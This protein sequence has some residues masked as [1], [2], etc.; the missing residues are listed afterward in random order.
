[1][2][3]L[4]FAPMLVAAGAEAPASR[5]A[6]S[7]QNGDGTVTITG[8]L[9]QWHKIT[10]QLAGPFAREQDNAPNPFTDLRFD[11]TL[12][13]ESGAP[14]YVVPGYFAAD[15]NAANTSATAGHIW[16][17]HLTP[18]KPGRWTYRVSFTRG[19]HVAMNGG[20]EP[21]APFDGEEGEFVVATSDKVGRDFRGKGRLEYVGGRYLRFAGSG[22]LF[23]KAGADAPETLLAYVDFDGTLAGKK[24]VPLKT[25][26]PH[27]RDW[28]PGDPAWRGGRGKGLIGALN[29]LAAQGANA[30]S[31]LTYNAG[32]DGDNVWPFVSR[33]DK[34][35]YDCSKLD[36]WGI[37]FDHA[38]R[39][40]L[41]LH[42]KLQETENDDGRIGPERTARATPEALD[43]GATGPERRLYLRELIARFGHALALN[44][45]L[46]EENTQTPDEQRAMMQ[47]ITETD[48]YHH[49]IVLHSYPQEQDA[50]Y[51]P[52]L[53]D[54][55]QLTGVSLQ[56]RWDEAHQRTFHWVQAAEAA[57]RAWVVCNDEQN[58]PETG[59]PPDFGYKGYAGKK[60]DGTRVGYNLDD[61]RRR[62]LWG[63]LLAGGA[64][65]EYYF[66]YA[67]S[68]NDLL[69]EDFRSREH[70]WRYARAAL[71]FFARNRIPLASMRN[72][73]ELVG[74]PQHDNSAYCFAEPDQI[75]LVYLPHGGVADLDLT[76]AEHTFSITWFNPRDEILRSGG[77]VH[78]GEHVT[79][80]A[81]S[82][83]EDW[84]GI[85]RQR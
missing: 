33:H 82:G 68:Q 36:Q 21:L 8:Q 28:R 81:P 32:G 57:G 69:A 6:A 67:L 54:R 40:G 23:L 12:V 38:T 20:G 50:V 76:A 24:N 39:R 42:F 18:D 80:V 29:Y 46:G 1:L 3:C 19:L 73:D 44:W 5:A 26:S 30:F 27:V 59:V 11:V 4:I 84:L 35:H 55:S 66:G 78:G 51:T 37:V 75:Y 22:D 61:I 48:P 16:R 71:N 79:L 43:G 72:V 14:R 34:L 85:L 77:D 64:G 70:S 17:A 31:F 58:P 7:A 47:F 60:R 62:T 74:N 65:V 49:P 10:V 83:G 13:H 52:L 63:T 2:S 45:N 41:F 53:G 9:R 56:N 25:W 15:G